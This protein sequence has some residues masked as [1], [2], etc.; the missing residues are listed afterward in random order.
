[1]EPFGNAVHAAVGTGGRRGPPHERR[2]SNRLR[3]DRA[4]RGGDRARPRRVEGVRD[5]TEPYRRAL[6]ATMGA[7]LLSIP[8]PRTRRTVLRRDTNGNGAEVVLEMRGTP[9]RSTR[10]RGCSRRWQD[11]VP[12]PAGPAGDDGSERSGDLQ[13][14]AA[15][16]HH[17]AGDVP[18]L[19]ADDDAALDRPR[20]L[21]PVITHRF[22]LDRFEEAFAT[23]ASGTS[24]KVIVFPMP[25]RLPSRRSAA[26][27]VR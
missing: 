23:A 27:E 3:A 17:R 19:A 2:R 26:A 25:T 4:V 15:P 14:G 7:D 16:R 20:R 24:A 12:R 21:S 10:E 13:G 18:D 5:R 22:P 1:M 6:A 9:A 11:V 8:R